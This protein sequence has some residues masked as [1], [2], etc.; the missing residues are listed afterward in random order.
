MNTPELLANAAAVGC[1]LLVL[2]A[3]PMLLGSYVVIQGAGVVTQLAWFAAIL[4][5]LVAAVGAGTLGLILL[6]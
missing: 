6:G 5:L 2:L 4:G 3:S 1:I